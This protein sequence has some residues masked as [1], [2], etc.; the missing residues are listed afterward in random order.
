MTKP[1]YPHGLPFVIDSC[2]FDPRAKMDLAALNIAEDKLLDWPLVYILSNQKEAYVGQTTSMQR[3]ALQ[4]GANEEKASF[5]RLNIIFSEEFNMSVITDYESRL[6]QLMHADQTFTITNK[7]GGISNANYFSKPEY[8]EMFKELWEELQEIKIAKHTIDE[9][10]DSAIFKYS[11]FKQL[12]ADQQIAFDKIKKAILGHKESPIIVEGVPGSGKTILAIFLF[13]YLKDSPEYKD[14]NIKLVIPQSSLRKTVKEVFRGT[15]NLNAKDVIGPSELIKSEHGY[16]AGQKNNYDVLLVDEAHRLHQRKNIMHHQVFKKVNHSLGLDEYSSEI[17]WILDQCATPVLFYDEFQV[18]GPSGIGKDLLKE[19]IAKP[20]K[21]ITL[22]SQM[23]VKGGD[24]YIS[25]I[26]AILNNEKPDR[27]SFSEKYKLAQFASFSDFE[28]CFKAT[29]AEHSLT[30]MIAGYAWPWKTKG[31]K[32]GYDIEIEGI[33][34]RWNSFTENW[35]GRGFDDPKIAHEMGSIHS[36]QGYDLSYA[37]VVFGNDIRFNPDSGEIE[38]NK[39]NYFDKYGKNSATQEELLQY[40]KNIY[41]VLLTRG[42]E[43]TYC[44]ACDKN[45]RNYLASYIDVV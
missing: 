38:V 26:S 37:F 15:M 41:Y 39:E 44:Y 9:L 31:G 35:V 13:K 45:L 10:E 1:K 28:A 25:Y 8:G 14:K 42:I 32:P 2:T 40:I 21:K 20:G 27:V 17:D 30:R 33:E 43:G 29:L 11:P 7:N 36:I 12:N 16:V 19:K 23:R 22:S 5:R 34:K 24:N 18:V 6:I 4:H 3:R